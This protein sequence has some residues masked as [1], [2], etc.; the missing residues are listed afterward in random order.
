M[1]KNFLESIKHLNIAQNVAKEKPTNEH[2]NSLKNKKN[3]LDYK[4]L[5][6]L[7]FKLFKLNT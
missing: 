4:R 7:T 6:K 2:K 3:C 5:L 1:A